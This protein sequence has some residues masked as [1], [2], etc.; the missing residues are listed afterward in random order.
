MTMSLEAG[1]LY[2]I[3]AR[4][5]KAVANPRR[6]EI[7]ELLTD[8][9]RPVSLLAERTG[10]P[11][12]AMSQHLA[13]LRGAGIVESTREGRERCYRLT[14]AA[15]GLAFVSLRQV[16]LRRLALFGQLAGSLDS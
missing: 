14:D 15:I 16:L 4:V 13:A 10:I 3:Q 11:Q 9:A 2:T 8:D 1:E 12:P 7:I 6:L 5:L